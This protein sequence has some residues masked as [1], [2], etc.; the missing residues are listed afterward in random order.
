MGN[1]KRRRSA[2]L[3]I[4]EGLEETDLV[5][6]DIVELDEVEESIPEDLDSEFT[7]S[8]D[9]LYAEDDYMLPE[10]EDDETIISEDDFEDYLA[11]QETQFEFAD[12]D[13]DLDDEEEDDDFDDDD[14]EDEDLSYL[15]DETVTASQ[16]LAG[17]E[18][19]IQDTANGGDPTTSEIAPGG[20][21]AKNQVSTDSEVYPTNSE[22]IAK[23]VRKFDRMANELQKMG[24]N[25]LAFRL[26]KL[27]DQLE[28]R[29]NK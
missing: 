19:M 18:D 25:K 13:E 6:N 12:D 9:D 5:S 8:C 28:N 17:V 16:E 4:I 27:S 14:E 7:E 24:M 26:D 20:N 15:E 2:L 29:R 23:I 3:S 22:Y 1:Y 21:E 11:S 10:D